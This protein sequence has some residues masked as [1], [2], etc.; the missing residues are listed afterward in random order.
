MACV[1]S[2]FFAVFQTSIALAADLCDVSTLTDYGCFGGHCLTDGP[3]SPPTCSPY[4]L[5]ANLTCN[6][7]LTCS[8]LQARSLCEAHAGCHSFALYSTFHDGDLALLYT[9]NK[10]GLIANAAW[11]V[12]IKGESPSP[13]PSPF[14]TG[15]C[16]RAH[17]CSLNGVCQAGIC[18]CHPGWQGHHC[19]HL[20]LKPI[21]N[22]SAYGTTPNVT[23]WGATIVAVNETYHMFVTE[24]TGGCGLSYWAS[25][26]QI[27]HATSKTLSGPYVK[28][29]VVTTP[30]T[31]NPQMVY[32]NR[33][34]TYMLFYIGGAGSDITGPHQCRSETGTP[35]PWG[36]P[37]AADSTGLLTS[38]SPWG[39][40]LPGHFIDCNNPSPAIH[41]NGTL[42]VACHNGAILMT[43]QREDGSFTPPVDI[44]QGHPFVPGRLP[45]VLC[46]SFSPIPPYYH[47]VPLLL[48][49]SL[50]CRQ[51]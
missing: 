21:G 2:L 26:S 35:G 48:R 11:S 31:S 40:W 14:P 38:K 4:L 12:F 15:P 33:T 22:I 44:A 6:G 5:L 3:A 51:L 28:Q 29:A 17:D 18:A 7:N 49:N 45:R 37:P 13:P 32:N 9:A 1:R 8:I 30:A 41:P 36:I 16:Q 43:R 39:P 50:C 19:Q 42:F 20:K 25:N 23:S 24:E 10:S 47:T 27:V 46:F 34:N